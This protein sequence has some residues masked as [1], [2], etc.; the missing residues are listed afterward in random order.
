MS[1]SVL[2]RLAALVVVTLVGLYYILFDAV[3]IHVV[4]RPYTVHVVVPDAGGAYSDAYVTYRGVEVGKVSAVHL[5]R[6]DVVLD[7]AIGHGVHI[8]TN[9]TA[10]VRELT[11][12]AEQYL[13]LVPGSGGPPYLQPGATIPESRTTI[14]VTVGQLLNSL[15]TLVNSLSAQDLNTLSSALATGLQGEGL[16][17]HSIIVDGSMLV[18]ALD[19][20]IP[21]T[22]RMIN[23]GQTVLSTFNGTSSEFAQ[24][25]A[26]LDQ[27][28]AQV[29]AS[30]SDLVGLLQNGASAGQTLDPF[31]AQTAGPTVSL[32]DA[33]ASSTN[34]AYA[35]QAAIKALFEVLP[36]FSQDVAT[37][38]SGG[39]I[40]F[41]LTFNT[42]DPVCPYTTTMVEPTS[43]VPVA[44]L[45]GNCH[46]E[47]PNL[48]QR[49]ADKAPPPG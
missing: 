10:N 4:D 18:T 14:P 49:G 7:L 15:N 5:E 43:L 19:T 20:A 45:T 12:A 30:N 26:N 31:L 34:V 23:A 48:L 25:S 40:R 17:L 16:N 32:I 39:Q 24:F 37:V 8:P 42:A 46:T 22:A 36:L 2:G 41:E 11:A 44:N 3:G 38:T 21:G 1:R 35:R 47:A 9:V 29:A 6:N 13:D 28:S 27:L 33:L